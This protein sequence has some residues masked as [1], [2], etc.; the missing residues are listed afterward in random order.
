MTE[1]PGPREE[2]GPES[3][4]EEG[5]HLSSPEPGYPAGETEPHGDEVPSPEHPEDIG[6]NP[7]DGDES[8]EPDQAG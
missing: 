4:P 3:A 8:D 2:D 5:E 7:P 6:S 1:H